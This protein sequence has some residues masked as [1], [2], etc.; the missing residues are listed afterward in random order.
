M[1]MSYVCYELAKNPD[2]QRRMQEE[3]DEAIEK[4]EGQ[5]PDYSAVQGL[6]YMEQVIMETLRCHTLIG[7]FQRACTKDFKIPGMDFTIPKGMEVHINSSGIH[8]DER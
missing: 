2:I 5:M 6:E 3:I 7:I 1:T 8:H 4:A